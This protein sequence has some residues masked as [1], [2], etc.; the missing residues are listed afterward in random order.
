MLGVGRGMLGVDKPAVIQRMAVT[1][2]CVSSVLIT[3]SS[4]SLPPPVSSALFKE[5]KTL[6]L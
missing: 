5:V 1:D 3:E 4:Y 2:L 6:C